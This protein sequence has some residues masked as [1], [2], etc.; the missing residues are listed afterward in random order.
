MLSSANDGI[1]FVWSNGGGIAD[2]FVVC[3]PLEYSAVNYFC[4]EVPASS[5]FPYYSVCIMYMI[6]CYNQYR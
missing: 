6:V 2:K 5:I 4:D 3:S 1:V